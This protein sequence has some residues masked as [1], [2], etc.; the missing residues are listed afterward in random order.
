MPWN[1][2]SVMDQR[3]EFV[4]LA[5]QEGANRREVCRRVLGSAGGRPK[6]V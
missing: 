5:L 1:E 6:G 3:R 4:R 2:V